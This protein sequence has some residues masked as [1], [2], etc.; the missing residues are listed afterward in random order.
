MFV[1]SF[2]SLAIRLL[3]IE[4]SVPSLCLFAGVY[5]QTEMDLF[6]PESIKKLEEVK[7]CG[8]LLAGFPKMNHSMND[9]VKISF[10]G[11]QALKGRCT[12]DGSFVRGYSRGG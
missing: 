5:S 10:D 4:A 2:N 11:V 8:E 9:M 7:I 1:I 6:L 3:K 12:G